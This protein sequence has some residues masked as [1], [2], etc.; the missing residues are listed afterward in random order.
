MAYLLPLHQDKVSALN[1]RFGVAKR[2]AR[3]ASTPA[4]PKVSAPVP[5]K[6]PAA[7]APPTPEQVAAHQAAAQANL[8]AQS[9]R[10]AAAA[11]RFPTAAAEEPE[12]GDA[13]A[14]ILASNLQ[15]GQRYA[16]QVS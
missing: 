5:A 4:R 3:A 2:R 13:A 1:Q 8:A 11:A 7:V 9:A 14:A 12:P 6:A 16:G 10:K 15:P